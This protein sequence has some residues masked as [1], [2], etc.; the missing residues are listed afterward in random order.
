VGRGEARVRE[1]EDL[2]RKDCEEK[3]KGEL[4]EYKGGWGYGS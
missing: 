4:G 1:I 2:S 3:E